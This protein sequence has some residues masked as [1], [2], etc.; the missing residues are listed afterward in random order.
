MLHIDV[1]HPMVLLTTCMYNRD[2]TS[3]STVSCGLV[4]A[5]MS[6]VFHNVFVQPNP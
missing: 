4:R 6:V 3:T 5:R 1:G 2:C